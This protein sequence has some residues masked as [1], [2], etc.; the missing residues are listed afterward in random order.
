MLVSPQ[1]AVTNRVSLENVKTFALH[2]TVQGPAG[3]LR[4]ERIRAMLGLD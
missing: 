4:K 1:A 3:V 2:G